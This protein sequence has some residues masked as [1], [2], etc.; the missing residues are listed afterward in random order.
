MNKEEIIKR[1]VGVSIDASPLTPMDKGECL[2][3]ME[4]YAEQERIKVKIEVLEDLQ[5]KA[6]VE[7]TA[8]EFG[9][10]SVRHNL[11]QQGILGGIDRMLDY[12]LETISQLKTLQ[13]DKT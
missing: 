2:I 5:I 10:G 6:I 3:C 8:I 9:G 7:K 13:N 4:A 12:I 11:E 1:W